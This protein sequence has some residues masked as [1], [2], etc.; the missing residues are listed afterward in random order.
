MKASIVG[1]LLLLVGLLAVAYLL[2]LQQDQLVNLEL[3]LDR[4]R[5]AYSP[6]PPADNGAVEKAAPAPRPRPKRQ[7]KGAPGV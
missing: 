6:V 2:Y 1:E 3:E 7:P 4:L 5:G